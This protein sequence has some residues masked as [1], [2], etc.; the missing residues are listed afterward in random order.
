M[1]VLFFKNHVHTNIGGGRYNVIA[2]NVMY[3][4]TAYSIQVDARG[5]THR[6]DEYLIPRLYVGVIL[7]KIKMFYINKPFQCRKLPTGISVPITR[8][9]QIK[10][11]K[12]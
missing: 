5:T 6:T 8:F 1:T 3:N 4:A 7:S 12:T 11:T 9:V 2:N 10:K